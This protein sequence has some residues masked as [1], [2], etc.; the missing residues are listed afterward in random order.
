LACYRKNCASPSSPGQLILPECMKLLPLYINCL[1]NCDALSGG[2]DMSIDDRTFNMFAV[3]TMHV[4]A[5]LAYLYPRLVPIVDAAT[6][7]GAPEQ[8][9]QQL[10]LLPSPVRCTVDKLRDDGVYCLDNGIHMFL[11]IGLSVSPEWI[12]GV[13]NTNS[14]A[15]IDIDR[16]KLLE[17][18]NQRSQEVTDPPKKPT[19]EKCNEKIDWSFLF[20]GEVGDWPAAL[21]PTASHA[22]DSG[23][24][25]RQAGICL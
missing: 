5:S 18:D 15:Q 19:L 3:Q 20:S 10:L 7:A 24:S 16:T 6:A 17:L 14:A 9:D 11:W 22:P 4:G 21:D 1:L 23:P 13:F 25:S 8:E 2:S 12:H